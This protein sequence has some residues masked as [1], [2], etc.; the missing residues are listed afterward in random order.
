[1]AS[2]DV[3]TEKPFG[4]AAPGLVAPTDRTLLAAGKFMAIISV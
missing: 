2:L 1:M 4:W 3:A